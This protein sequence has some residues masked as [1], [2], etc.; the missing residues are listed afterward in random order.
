ML[1]PI[2]TVLIVE[3]DDDLRDAAAEALNRAGFAAFTARSVKGATNLVRSFPGRCLIVL[4]LTLTDGDGREVLEILPQVNGAATRFPVLVAS[5]AED[6][7]DLA[8]FPYVVGV[9][10]KPFELSSLLTA[11]FEQA[12]SAPN[13]LH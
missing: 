12:N 6:A 13:Q 4:D 8:K 5:G 11:I 3:D 1:G 10:Q 7:K 9:I 2:W